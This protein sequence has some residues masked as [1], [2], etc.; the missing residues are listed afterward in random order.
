MLV[1]N[2]IRYYAEVSFL[3]FCLRYN[4]SETK[5]IKLKQTIEPARTGVGPKT[6]KLS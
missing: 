4:N 6:K 3:L 5:H 1:L 2:D